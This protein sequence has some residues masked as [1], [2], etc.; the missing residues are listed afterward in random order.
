MFNSYIFP[1]VQP[2]KIGDLIGKTPSHDL[3]ALLII[4]KYVIKDLCE[5]INEYCQVTEEKVLVVKNSHMSWRYFIFEKKVFEINFIVYV[6]RK[7]PFPLSPE[8]L[9][10]LPSM[11]GK[12]NKFTRVYFGY[13]REERLNAVYFPNKT[14][15]YTSEY[16]IT[17][18][19]GRL[20]YKISRKEDYEDLCRR[21]RK[22]YTWNNGNIN[23]CGKYY[24]KN[25]IVY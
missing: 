16:K 4:E 10:K 20:T 12:T 24:S 22:I 5:I 8:D 17:S 7:N 14:E 2:F 21:N 13:D 19:G 25:K 18:E 3:R 9:R 11:S 23:N 1:F 6:S 15:I